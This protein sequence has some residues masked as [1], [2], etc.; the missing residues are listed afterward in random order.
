MKNIQRKLVVPIYEAAVHLVVA[1]DIKAERAKFNEQFGEVDGCNWDGL[2]SWDENGTF[3]IFLPST[4][5]DNCSVIAHEVFHLT[6]RILEWT[7]SNFDAEHHEQG[8]LLHGY[9]MEWVAK[10]LRK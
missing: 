10:Q 4:N 6:H 3:G 1:D 2:C 8:A 5:A 9:L 7:N